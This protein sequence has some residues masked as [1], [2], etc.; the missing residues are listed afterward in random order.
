MTQYHNI[1]LNLFRVFVAVFQHRSISRA[2]EALGVTPAS[3]SQSIK[4]LSSDL[5]TPLFVR[6]GRGIAPT[7][8]SQ[9]LIEQVSPLISQFD[10]VIEGCI[11]NEQKPNSRTLIVHAPE[12]LIYKHIKDSEKV[13]NDT[14][15]YNIEWVD[16]LY[17][18]SD[19][20][21]T[22][23]F[24]NADAIIDIFQITEPNICNDF[25]FE[26]EMVVV[27]ANNHPRVSDSITEA[28]FLR[29]SHVI[30]NYQFRNASLF[31]MF[32]N[33]PPIRRKIL[34]TQ[35]SIT[36]MLSLVARSE[37]LCLCPKQFALQ[38][39]QLLPIK[40]LPFP[41]VIEPI[42]Y[43]LIYPAEQSEAESVKWLYHTLTGE[44]Q[45]AGLE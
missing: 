21:E 18:S 34:S 36:S 40:T 30:L 20:Y 24:H 29:E 23:K 5:N 22:L 15:R 28:Q 31:E 14:T 6:Q 35:T 16:I 17:R 2:S 4:K 41:G 12:T 11:Y 13:N 45:Q 3:V 32:Y 1:D 38:Q 7:V 44:Q 9:Q 33:R 10:N 39:A 8:H 37:A 26:D 27:A 42:N 43:W 19:S 25:L